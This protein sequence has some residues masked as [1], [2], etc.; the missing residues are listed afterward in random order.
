MASFFFM[1]HECF[2]KIWLSQVKVKY[3]LPCYSFASIFYVW[4]LQ[5]TVCNMRE[6]NKPQK[7]A[8]KK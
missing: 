8:E 4:S 6:D 5:D 1:E 2:L 3:I 7:A